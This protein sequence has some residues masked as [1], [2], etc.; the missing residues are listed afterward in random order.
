MSRKADVEK[1]KSVVEKI[2]QD[3]E[4]ISVRHLGN[5]DLAEAI[6]RLRNQQVDLG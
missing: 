2:E 5:E 4:E 1:L 6:D 3:K